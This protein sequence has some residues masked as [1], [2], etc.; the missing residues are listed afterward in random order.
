MYKRCICEISLCIIKLKS[1]KMMSLFQ[2]NNV[3]RTDDQQHDDALNWCRIFLT[4]LQHKVSSLS[5]SQD[6]WMQDYLGDFRQRLD[7]RADALGGRVREKHGRHRQ[8]KWGWRS[9][10][11]GMMPAL[12]CACA[13]VQCSRLLRSTWN[14]YTL[15]ILY[16]QLFF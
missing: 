13:C 10:G 15:E 12:C 9:R 7:R 6:R 2:N 5:F 16:I 8:G 14:R 3:I 11:R 1:F 4:S